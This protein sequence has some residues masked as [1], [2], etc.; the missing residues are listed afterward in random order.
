MNEREFERN[1][2]KLKTLKQEKNSNDD[3][4]AE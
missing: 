3:I 2:Y 4:I 1:I